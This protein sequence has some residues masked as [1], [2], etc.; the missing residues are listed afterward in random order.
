MID[1]DALPGDALVLDVG[2]WAA[3]LPRADWVMDIAPFETRNAFYTQRGEAPPTCRVT[4]ERWVQRDVCD[5]E[6]WPFEDGQFDFVYCS[7]T[8]EDVRD[9]VHVC[10]E[11]ARVGKAG[12]VLTVHPQ[13]ELTKGIESPLWCGWRHHRWLVLPEADA[14]VFLAK[15]QHVHNP[16]WPSA[17]AKRLPRRLFEPLAIPWDVTLPAREEVVLDPDELDRRLKAILAGA[18]ERSGWDRTRGAALTAAWGAYAGARRGA[19]AAARALGREGGA[20]A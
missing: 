8:V 17:R 19:G 9:P 6:P 18:Y 16:L 5:R 11:M 2:G 10:G 3:P 20:G 13:I 7:Q 4:R 14:V 15:P 1:L 12:L